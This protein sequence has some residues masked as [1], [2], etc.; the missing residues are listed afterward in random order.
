MIPIKYE[1]YQIAVFRDDRDIFARTMRITHKP[2]G[3]SVQGTALSFTDKIE[4][5]LID[6]LNKLLNTEEN[7]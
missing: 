6:E 7:K 4:L 5:R 1:D 3:K 2:S